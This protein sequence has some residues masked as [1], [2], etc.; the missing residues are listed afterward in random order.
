MSGQNAGPL[1]A[2]AS[3]DRPAASG[4]N[5]IPTLL[6]PLKKPWTTSI[7]LRKTSS[8]EPV[9]AEYVLSS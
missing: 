5:E 8:T 6:K 2:R 3:V 9:T 4:L 7:T 1:R